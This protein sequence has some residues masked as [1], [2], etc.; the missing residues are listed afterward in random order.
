[1]VWP[2]LRSA[3]RLRRRPG[4]SVVPDAVIAARHGA[5]AM[6]DPTEGGVRAGLH[7]IAFASQGRLEID[8]DR[9]VVLP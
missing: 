4:I 5:S 9:I 3:Q 1:M 6:P 2:S 7:E 8:L